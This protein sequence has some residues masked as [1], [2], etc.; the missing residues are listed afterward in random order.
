MLF[1]GWADARPDRLAQLEAVIECTDGR[2]G[3]NLFL[4]ADC[5][6][7]AGGESLRAVV[8]AAEDRA[9]SAMSFPLSLFAR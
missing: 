6:M 9:D 8:A 5:A 4:V 1:E 3:S 7:K 2:D